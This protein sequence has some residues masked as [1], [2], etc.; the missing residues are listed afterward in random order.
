MTNRSYIRHQQ[1]RALYAHAQ[2][3]ACASCHPPC[4]PLRGV[5]LADGEFD[6]RFRRIP[7]AMEED[8]LKR[9]HGGKWKANNLDA[10][11]WR[12]YY[13]R[14]RQFAE[15]GY[16]KK[17]TDPA[18][19]K[20]FDLME[21]LKRS[22][23]T[24]AGGKL[25]TLTEELKTLRKLPLKDFLEQG[26]KAVRRHHRDYL[27][28]E[29][30]TTLASANS[31]AKWKD[32]ERR[33]YLYPNLRYETAGDERV[34]E[35]HAALDGRIYPVASAFWDT[36]MPPNGWRCRCIVIQ[37]DEPTTGS[38][39][40]EF[41]P[42]KGFRNN[43]GRSG[44]LFEDDHPYFNWAKP[45][46][47]ALENASE[48][49]RAEWETHEVY[50]LAEKYVGTTHKL[51]GMS[52]PARVDLDFISTTLATPPF[53]GGAGGVRNDLLTVL[54]LLATSV[55]LVSIEGNTYIY[56]VLVA[57]YTFRLKV[58]NDLFQIIQ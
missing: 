25:N 16:G 37:T 44:K 56:N 27:Q 13:Q 21:R 29:L 35:S 9:L 55:Q 31:A 40:L 32:I 39:A 28:A 22:G 1:L 30:D 54:H 50:K 15:A 24:F 42:P 41:E 5:V 43:P 47:T 26:K 2:G 36:Y 20:E 7:A 38:E 57:G 3:C 49:L 46:R 17:L 23:S 11:I 53:Q 33:A 34:R 14:F 4:P 58:S 48:A 12:E 6:N 51:P 19:W 52:Q 45:D 10:P 8:F 18:D